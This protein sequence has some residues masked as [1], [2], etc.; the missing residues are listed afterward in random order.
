MFTTKTVNLRKFSRKN[1]G[2]NIFSQDKTES[3]SQFG[4]KAFAWL[5]N[6]EKGKLFFIT[7]VKIY[8]IF[9]YIFFSFPELCHKANRV[10]EKNHFLIK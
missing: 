10:T 4:F 6:A 1:L 7:I 3:F 5:T 8:N 9:L 2:K